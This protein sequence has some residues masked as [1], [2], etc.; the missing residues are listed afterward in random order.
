MRPS[1][2]NLQL[3]IL[4]INVFSGIVYFCEIILESSQNISE[5][6]TRS[7][8]GLISPLTCF[9]QINHKESLFRGQM[10]IGWRETEEILQQFCNYSSKSNKEVSK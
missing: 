10:I 2:L 3:E 9:F 8:A 4:T 6:T 1:S 7:L 5:T